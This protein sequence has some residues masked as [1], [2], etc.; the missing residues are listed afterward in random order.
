MNN[1]NNVNNLTS[2]NAE[3]DAL[4]VAA[5]R[6]YNINPNLLKAVAQVESNFRPDA[7]SRAGAQGI[8]QLMPATAEHLGVTDSF[9]PAQNIMAGARYLREQLDRFDG[10]IRLALAA[11]NAG[12]PAVQQHGGIPP[13]SETQAY[14]PK[15]L[16]IFTRGSIPT[17]SIPQEMISFPNAVNNPNTP[18]VPG[19]SSV[20]NNPGNNTQMNEMLQQMMMMMVMNMQ[21]GMGSGFGGR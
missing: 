19:D 20:A 5:G 13:F 21:M 1:V 15:V 9:N 7:V 18:G 6:Q 16:G 12:W 4:F 17:D 10:D 14:V 11:Y 8:M 2:G 3:L